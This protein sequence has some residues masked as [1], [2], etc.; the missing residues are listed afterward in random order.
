MSKGHI[1]IF[2][3]KAGEY[4]WNLRARNGEIVSDSAEGYRHLDDCL[5]IAS[6]LHPGVRIDI[7][8]DGGTTTLIEG[9]E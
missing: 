4:R 7:D 8:E 6:E 9:E 1:H 2:K 3:D 5:V